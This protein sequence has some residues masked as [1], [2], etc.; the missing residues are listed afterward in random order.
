MSEIIQKP[1]AGA[2][3]WQV[4]TSDYRYNTEFQIGEGVTVMLKFM[5]AT[6]TFKSGE[7][8]QIKQIIAPTLELH[9]KKVMFDKSKVD[10]E[11]W[12]KDDKAGVTIFWGLN[13]NDITD[14][15]TK[16]NHR[17]KT[18]GKYILSIVNLEV[19]AGLVKSNAEMV[20]M[21]KDIKALM[22]ANILDMIR[23]GLESQISESPVKK[24]EEQKEQVTERLIKEINL[25]IKSFGLEMKDLSLGL[26]EFVQE[27]RK[28]IEEFDPDDL[29]KS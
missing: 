15:D 23:Q 22:S 27:E 2:V 11:I 18:S 3:Y 21:D 14:L 24:L 29:L 9:K 16:K 19:F 28:I 20:M 5:D 26:F 17:L 1:Q 10:C 12:A 8:G 6:Y 7:G 13:I 4:D 25:K